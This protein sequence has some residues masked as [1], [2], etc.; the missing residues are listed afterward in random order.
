MTSS[1]KWAVLRCD[2]P[3]DPS[4]DAS[5]NQSGA[6]S[7][8]EPP[9]LGP[10]R[11]MGASASDVESTRRSC[12]ACGHDAAELPPAREIRAVGRREW[13]ASNRV[14]RIRRASRLS[15]ARSRMGQGPV[16]AGLLDFGAR[17]SLRGFCGDLGAL[18]RPAD[19]SCE[20]REVFASAKRHACLIGRPGTRGGGTSH[21]S[22]RSECPESADDACNDDSPRIFSDAHRALLRGP[23]PPK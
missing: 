9:E 4:N 18:G 12:D 10:G 21:H 13:G 22:C 20:C 15:P 7:W 8:Y 14:A 1:W 3:L 23:V 16:W 17:F 6:A 11:R 19:P 2:D 5:I